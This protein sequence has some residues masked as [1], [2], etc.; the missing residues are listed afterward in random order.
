MFAD[1]GS[2]AELAVAAAQAGA[3]VVLGRYETTL[4]R[5][6]KPGG[7][8]ATDADLAA[9][10]AVIEVIKA[11]S[12]KFVNMVGDILERGAAQG[13]FRSG[14]DPVQLNITIAAIGYYYLTNRDTTSSISAST[15]P[16]MF[17]RMLVMS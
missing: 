17:C 14:V 10:Q 5:F 8:F 13:V 12:R 2:D 9:E 11:A 3:A 1:P 7:D 4:T 15:S 16:S 6:G